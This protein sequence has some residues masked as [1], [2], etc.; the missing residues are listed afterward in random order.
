MWG[1]ARDAQKLQALSD[2]V[3]SDR[4]RWSSVDVADTASVQAWK[5]ACEEAGFLPDCIVLNAAL[6]LPDMEGAYRHS[7]GSRTL[8]VTLEGA[9][10]CV[11][12][13]LPLFL[14][15][16]HGR[17]VA[18]SSAMALRPSKRSA[19]YAA[20]KAG[21]SMAFR[22]FALRYRRDGVQFAQIC[23]GPVA[24][25]MWEGRTHWMVPSAEQAARRLSPFILSNRTRTFFYPRCSTALLRVSCFL[26]DSLFSF[27]GR[28]ILH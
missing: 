13:F 4:F 7:E 6:Q 15:R 3:R 8:H 1:V 23:L 5:T 16:R 22:S 24:T 2:T 18:I 19:A 10:R 26:P 17:F 20:A 27:F 12:V 25:A 21:L 11:D 14:A 9:L 28:K